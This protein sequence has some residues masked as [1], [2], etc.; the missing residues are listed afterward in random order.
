MRIWTIHPK[1]LDRIGIVA[2]WRETLL[3]KHVL[4]GRSKGYS[5]H[6]QLDR[7]KNTDNP[8]DSINQYLTIVY[9]DS[10]KRGYHFNKDKI[11]WE[12]KQ[13]I[14]TVTSGQL[15][16]EVSHLLKKLKNRD[17]QSYIKIKKNKKFDVHP[18]FQVVEGSIENWEKIQ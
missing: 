14:I 2:L 16:Y 12:F 15:K 18:M 11:N 1:Y 17:I 6:P 8:V 10:V 4:E 5:N 9:R 7:F 3:A 13:T